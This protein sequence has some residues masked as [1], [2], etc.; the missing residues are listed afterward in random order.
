MLSEISVKPK[1]NEVP[2][3]CSGL[4]LPAAHDVPLSA[5]FTAHLAGLTTVVSCVFP[6]KLYADRDSPNAAPA[7][8][9][10]TSTPLPN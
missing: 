8:P 5:L 7:D 3:D 9:E 6:L 1:T 2:P 4:L 10:Y